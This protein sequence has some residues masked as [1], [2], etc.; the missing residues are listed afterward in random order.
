MKKWSWIVLKAFITLLSFY[1]IQDQLTDRAVTKSLNLP[2]NFIPVMILQLFL[3]IVNWILEIHRW[4]ISIESSERISFRQASIDVLGGLTMNWIVPFT[5]GDYIIR[6]AAKRDKYRATSAIF[7]NRVI[8]LFLTL[9]V[10]LY[11]LISLLDGNGSYLLF[12]IF[13]LAVVFFVADRIAQGR[14]SQYFTELNRRTLWEIILISTCR[15]SIFFIQFVILITL[16]NPELD[17]ITISSGIGWIF[18]VRTSIPSLFGGVGLREAS[19]LFFFQDIIADTV[20]V[21]FPV[22]VLWVLNT[23]LPSLL[24]SLLLWK[25]KTQNSEDSHNIA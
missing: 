21:V 7:L 13:S 10:G 3:M 16:F 19:A 11:G 14:F 17:L 22:F 15:Y 6:I 20:T 2:D 4:K 1:F 25:F 23:A 24:G 12:G 9:L 18:L 8:M 5:V